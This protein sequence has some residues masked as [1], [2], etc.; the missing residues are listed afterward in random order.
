[1]LTGFPTFLGENTFNIFEKASEGKFIFPNDIISNDTI[2]LINKIIVVNADKRMNIDQMLSHPFLLKEY[3]D[4]NFLE[5]LPC[6]SE[7][8]EDFYNVRINLVKKYQKAKKICHDLKLIKLDDELKRKDEEMV[9][10]IKNKDLLQKE[11]DD[12]INDINSLKR[13]HND[14]NKLFNDKLN[15]LETQIE[16]DL[17]NIKYYGYVNEEKNESEESG[18]SS[19][20]EE[21]EK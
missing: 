11:Y 14:E 8:E 19:S 9:K 5:N 15:F 10:L 16:N 21:N 7:D 12:C 4:K 2:D 17:F 6:L 18:S 1:M 3:E 13:T 20:E